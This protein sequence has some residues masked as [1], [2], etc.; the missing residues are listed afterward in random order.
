M[1]NVAPD[2]SSLQFTT[3][4]SQYPPPRTRRIDV[5]SPDLASLYRAQGYL[6]LGPMLPLSDIVRVR[7]R[8]DALLDSL[9]PAGW[10]GEQEVLHLRDPWFLSVAADP[11]VLDVV[12]R[13]IG[14]DIALL[15][16]HLH[17]RRPHDP[18]I[19]PWHIDGGL[20]A[21]RLCPVEVVTVCL[22]LHD[23]RAATG[24]LH[25]I[26]G[27]HTRTPDLAAGSA[28]PLH[29]VPDEAFDPDQAVALDLLAGECH[30]HDPWII[31][32]SGPN[33]TGGRWCGLILRYIPTSVVY[34]PSGN[35]RRSIYLLRGSD[36]SEGRTSYTPLDPALAARGGGRRS[37]DLT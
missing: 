16:T 14:P 25:V 28:E 32:G 9:A 24:C 27:S 6:K 37:W 2:L 4:S 1:A 13:I 11:R 33:T 34:A 7:A 30:L 35:R 3:S 5:D 17:A 12:E 22:A 29:E 10:I 36:R 23:S 18:T 26:P 19:S 20:L 31:H 21:E 8:V 15:S